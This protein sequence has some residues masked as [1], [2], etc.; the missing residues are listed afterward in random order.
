MVALAMAPISDMRVEVMAVEC[1]A[2]GTVE[3]DLRVATQENTGNILQNCREHR[4]P[5]IRVASMLFLTLSISACGDRKS[6]RYAAYWGQ[7]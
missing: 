5:F 2:V 7:A 6:L 3:E 1:M 4:V